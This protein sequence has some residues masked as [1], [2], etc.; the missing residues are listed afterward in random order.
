MAKP[1]PL[2]PEL[3][4]AER[5]FL[6]LMD[7]SMRRR[8][9]ILQ[10]DLDGLNVITEAAT[11][12]YA[13]T[14][15]IAAL[16]GAR[17][18]TALARG[19]S[20]YGTARDAADATLSL[21]RLAGVERRIEVIERL[22]PRTMGNCDILTNSGHLR[23][24][25]RTVI[26]WL[27]AGAVIALMFEAWELRS[28]DLDL[29]A[30]HEHGIRV[31][32]VNERHPDVAVFPFLGPLCSLLLSR[33]GYVPAGRRILLLCDNPFAG[34]IRDWLVADGAIVEL[35][36]TALGLPAGPWEVVV[37]SLTPRHEPRL[38]T[39]EFRALARVAPGALVAQ[40]F[41]DIDRDAARREGF[42][43]T[44]AREPNKG[45][46]GI[47]LSELGHEPIV[48]LQA[49]GLRAGEIVFRSG[50]LPLDGVAHV[51]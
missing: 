44:P 16:A 20:R 28:T 25:T 21:A 2:S 43:L 8:I 4:Q 22:E 31:A 26:G 7:E 40:F 41:G 34:F 5:R 36:D 18:V 35:A 12:V 10:L 42:A 49:G 3:V 30:C 48:R 9:G 50:A 6:K 13:C 29:P 33:A 46:M 38:A 45:H 11:G 37:V 39:E 15:V 27:P 23:P 17:K 51:L 1:A 19:T 24:I 14:A 32:A 47:L